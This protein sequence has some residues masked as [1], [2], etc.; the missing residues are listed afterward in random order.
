MDLTQ[1]L[2]AAQRQPLA[3]APEGWVP[4]RVVAKGKKADIWIFSEIGYWGVRAQDIVAALDPIKDATE[5][6]L[7]L[8]SPGGEVFDGLAIYNILAAHPAKKITRNYGIAASMASVLFL[9]GEERLVGTN[10]R[11]MIHNASGFAGGTAD[12]ISKYVDLLNSINIEME[13]LYA[14]VTGQPIEQV[15]AWMAAETWF[16]ATESTQKGFA[17]GTFTPPNAQALAHQFSPP[18]TQAQLSLDPP[19]RQPMTQLLTALG[20][21]ADASEEQALE[22]L[23]AIKLAHEKDLADEKSSS[24]KVLASVL[25][26]AAPSL[27]E[28]EAIEIADL[29]QIGKTTVASRLLASAVAPTL[30]PSSVI[31]SARKSSGSQAPADSSADLARLPKALQGLTFT[32]ATKQ[33]PKAIESLCSADFAAFNALYRAEFGVDYAK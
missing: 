18:A 6:T 32:E 12:Q 24:S 16:T 29:F 4:F 13:E 5:I 8:N 19:K 31:E 17:T 21:S 25:S 27:Q 11:L 9:V 15:K 22:A 2:S 33:Q 3:K 14:K 23:A 20:V 30:S 10:A 1:L 7:H 26:T 28:A